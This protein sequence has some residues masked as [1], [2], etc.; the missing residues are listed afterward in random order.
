MNYIKII[1][2]ISLYFYQV[3]TDELLR[4]VASSNCARVNVLLDAG[5]SVTAVDSSATGN[6]AL[7]WAASFGSGE[8]VRLLIERGADVDRTNCD[9][10]TP[11]HDAVQRGGEEIVKL[12]IDAGAG[13]DVPATGCLLYTSP[14]PRGS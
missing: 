11:L 1:M 12:L 6:T 9:G 2:T 13:Q 8:E 5:L 7:H 14:S 4:A 10:A 3:F